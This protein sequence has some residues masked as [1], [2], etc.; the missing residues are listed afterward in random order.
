GGGATTGAQPAHD[1][2]YAGCLLA[3][4]HRGPRGPGRGPVA[5]R[6]R[7]R[8]RAGNIRHTPAIEAVVQDTAGQCVEGDRGARLRDAAAVTSGNGG[9]PVPPRP[10]RSRPVPISFHPD[11][12]DHPSKG[13][14]WPSPKEPTTPRTRCRSRSSSPASSSSPRC[15]WTTATSAG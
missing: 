15:T 13:P 2:A 12:P 10:C 8:Q 3:D 14:P 1:P 7:R 9:Q 4:H 11:P 5:H 6:S